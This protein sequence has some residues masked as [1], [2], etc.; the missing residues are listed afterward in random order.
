MAEPKKEEVAP[1]AKVYSYADLLQFENKQVFSS[2]GKM[3]LSTKTT[4]P[5][6]SFGSAERAA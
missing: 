3:P 2:I 5:I 4:M 1:V 6:Y